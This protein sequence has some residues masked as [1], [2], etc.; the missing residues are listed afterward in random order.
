MP[1]VW[2]R[3]GSELLL[4]QLICSLTALG[5]S[6]VSGKNVTVCE[7]KTRVFVSSAPSLNEI[8]PKVKI[9]GSSES[10]LTVKSYLTT[11]S[12]SSSVSA[13]SGTAIVPAGDKP[14][15]KAV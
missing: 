9:A 10:V 11:L 7:S 15:I 5:I 2:E 12:L 6:T 8:A 13:G 4:V 14:E 1:D 3:P